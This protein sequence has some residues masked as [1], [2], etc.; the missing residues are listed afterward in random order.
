MLGFTSRQ[1]SEI[2]SGEYETQISQ[3]SVENARTRHVPLKN[4]ISPDEDMELYQS[5]DMP[6]GDYMISCDYHSPYHAEMW[7]NRLVRIADKFHIKKN[8]IVG[9]L[10]DMDFAKYTLYKQAKKEGEEDSS[11]DK[12]ACAV[13][14]V[15]QALDY[16]DKNYLVMGNHEN[17]IDRLTDGAVQ[18][19]HIM[20]LFW[21]D[22]F[23]QKI[24]VSVYDKMWIGDEWL[25][26]HPRSY[27]Q[28]SGSVAVR[29][30]EKFHRHVMNAHGHFVAL[31][32]DRSGQYMGIDLGGM[33]DIRKVEYINKKT[34]THPFWNNGFGMIYNNRF[35]H[36][37]GGTDWDWWLK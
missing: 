10:F 29:L 22:E 6:D 17:R 20:R 21:G 1:I 18:S 4:L 11:L 31:R 37:H 16:F 13:Q 14:P 35:Y 5:K 30:A 9:D 34:T 19:R 32:Y 25:V 8:I 33:F 24:E 3:S 36:F 12:E 23:Q 27:S 28:I 7:I 2:L 26:V 15:I